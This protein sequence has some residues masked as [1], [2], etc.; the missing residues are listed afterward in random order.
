MTMTEVVSVLHDAN[1]SHTCTP[2]V[3]ELAVAAFA[4]PCGR[5]GRVKFTVFAPLVAVN[6]L[7]DNNTVV[8]SLPTR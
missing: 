5:N 4:F 7:D 8:P 2:S 1:I 6:G 3:K